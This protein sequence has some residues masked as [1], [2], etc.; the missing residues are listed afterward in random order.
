MPP[1]ADTD[2]DPHDP[3][4]NL[5]QHR[6][7]HQRH[8]LGQVQAPDPGRRLRRGARRRPP[9][10][11]ERRAGHRHQHGRG[12]ARLAGGHGA[13][14]EP[15]RRRA[16]HRPR[17]DH[18]RLVQVVGDRGRAQVRAGQG[19]RQLHQPE[20]GRGGV[21]GAGEEGP[22]LRRRGRGHGLRRGRPGRHRGPQVR[23]LPARLPHPGRRDRLRP[24]GHHLR[25]Q[26]LRRRHRHRRAQQLRGRL[27]RGHAPHQAR[28]ALRQGLRRRVQRVL[29]VPRQ[30]PGARGDPLGLSVPR[31]QGRHG[32]GYRQRRPARGLR[33]PAGGAARCGRG[34]DPEPQPGGHR[35]PDRP[36]AQ[37]QGRRLHRREQAGPVLARCP[38]G[39]AHRARPDQGRHRLHRRGH[40]RGA[41]EA[42]RAD[43][44]HRRPADGRHERGR[45]PVRRGQDVP[46]PGG[47]VRPRDEEVRR[48]PGA[49]SGG[50]RSA[51]A[52][53]RARS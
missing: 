12:D 2:H 37:V 28:T 23:D 8:R 47:Q 46:A 30:Q 44:R 34:R 29:L 52:T 25:P 7:A 40:R 48:L 21:S 1:S 17:A 5:H 24:R 6:R 14:P 4:S 39:E 10:G 41:A 15:D 13:L 19:H 35:A 32:H 51:R 49:L 31:H 11:R 26:H 27:H 50:R 18:D 9:T 45:R 42:R 33:R 38:G 16:G 36:G 53:P 3:T 20:G 22:P 43:Q